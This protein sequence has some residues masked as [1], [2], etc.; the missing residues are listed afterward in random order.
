MNAIE[1]D[2]TMVDAEKNRILKNA[3]SDH[4]T[5]FLVASFLYTLSISNKRRSDK[6]GRIQSQGEDIEEE[7]LLP[8]SSKNS[9]DI[10]KHGIIANITPALSVL[11]ERTVQLTD[12][13]LEKIIASGQALLEPLSNVEANLDLLFSHP[14]SIDSTIQSLCNTS[15]YQLVVTNCEIY[16]ERY[17]DVSL[18]RGLR[19]YGTPDEIIERCAD[20]TD[21]GVKELLT[22]PAIICNENTKYHGGTDKNQLAILAKILRIRKGEDEYRIRFYPVAAFPQAI[23]NE[24][25]V[26]FGLCTSKTLATLNTSHWTVRKNNLLEIFED[27]GITFCRFIMLYKS[28]ILQS[29]LPS[30]QT[31]LLITDFDKLHIGSYLTIYPQLYLPHLENDQIYRI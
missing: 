9:H 17:A 24:Y 20:L 7:T 29:D 1:N 10:I 28:S 31:E 13:M 5:D 26:D 27:V 3:D 16:G 19:F 11:G 21:E 15:F 25:A 30:D 23:L 2:D 6:K 22:Y 18:K 14:D 4:L 8:D 12:W